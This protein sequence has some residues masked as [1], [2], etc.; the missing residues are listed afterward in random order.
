MNE[1]L[2]TDSKFAASGL[3]QTIVFVGLMGAGKS[4]VG[5]RLA[6]ILGVD[7]VDADNEIEKAAGCSISEI[8]ARFGE[9]EF[10]S[11]E[12]KVIARLLENEPHILAT[13]GGAFMAEETR[14]AIAE[15]AVSVWLKADLDILFERVSRRSHRPLLET[16]NPKE[17]L[18]QL[19]EQR[20]PTYAEA[21]ITVESNADPIDETVERVRNVIENYFK[22][23]AG[24]Q[25][26]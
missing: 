25:A 12:R 15:N 5:R 14:D 2:S 6:Q 7:F 9:E 1:T 19:M 13:G 20:D 8:F 26:Q 21:D 16:E 4:A 22:T 24:K 11:G 23:A 17:T 18:R 10:R 3:P